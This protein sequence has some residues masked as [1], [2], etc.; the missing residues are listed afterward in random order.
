MSGTRFW[1][2]VG[3][4]LTLWRV[5]HPTNEHQAICT[6]FVDQEEEG[7]VHSE[8]D[9]RGE[10]HE[11]HLRQS[12]SLCPLLVH[13]DGSLVFQLWRQN[14]RQDRHTRAVNTADKVEEKIEL[15]ALGSPNSWKPFQKSFQRNLHCSGTDQWGQ[16]PAGSQSNHNS[17]PV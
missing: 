15:R 5:D 9:L 1:R 6:V 4:V 3:Q 13:G 14:M 17:A 12:S 11:A 8:A 2:M 16:A 10:G 7:M